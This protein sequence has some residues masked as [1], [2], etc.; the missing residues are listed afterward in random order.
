MPFATWE[1][2][3]RLFFDEV[4][5]D[6]AV[7]SVIPRRSPAAGWYRLWPGSGNALAP[8]L[9]PALAK[10]GVDITASAAEDASS[11]AASMMEAPVSQPA[12]TNNTHCSIYAGISHLLHR[13]EFLSFCA[14]MYLFTGAV[15]GFHGD[16]YAR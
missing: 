7:G 1:A 15:T 9:T 5:D 14:C 13:S 6:G 8:S 2:G 16:Q 3:P 10:E 12:S 4:T 11:R